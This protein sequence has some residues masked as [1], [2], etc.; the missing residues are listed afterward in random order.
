M[1]SDQ[2]IKASKL[3]TKLDP[4]LLSTVG[5]TP[6]AMKGLQKY[7]KSYLNKVEKLQQE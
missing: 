5:V 1:S 4:M 3:K 2:G 6:A 7:Q